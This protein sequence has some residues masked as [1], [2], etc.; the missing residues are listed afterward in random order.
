M[1]IS[2]DNLLDDSHSNCFS[3]VTESESAHAWE[4]IG[5]FHCDLARQSESHHALVSLL[6]ESRSGELLQL[7]CLSVELAQESFDSD[8]FDCGVQV[9]NSSESL[10]EKIILRTLSM[11][12]IIR[13]NRFV[14]CNLDSS[15]EA[16]TSFAD[17]CSVAQNVSFSDVIVIFNPLEANFEVLSGNPNCDRV[18][19]EFHRGHFD[20]T[21]RWLHNEL[22]AF[23]ETTSLELAHD[24]VSHVLVFLRDL[25]TNYK[26]FQWCITY[27]KSNLSGGFTLD[28]W[29][30]VQIVKK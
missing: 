12:S 16:S 10:T 3:F 9:D 21:T 23:G 30:V 27:T 1:F 19:F 26:L 11:S 7:L 8:F 17:V 6:E 22:F 24:H 20:L 29:Q 18:V 14:F 25:Q 5:E 2:F 4:V 13:D 28:S 15:I